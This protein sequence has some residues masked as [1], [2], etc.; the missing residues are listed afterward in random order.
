MVAATGYEAAH[1]NASSRCRMSA[2]TRAADSK[3]MLDKEEDTLI[4]ARKKEF[5]AQQT[6][7]VAPKCLFA[8]V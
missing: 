3:Q 1:V 7:K 4:N 2:A 8:I 6:M 5:L